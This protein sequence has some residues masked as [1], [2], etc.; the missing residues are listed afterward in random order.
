MSKK[1][2]EQ[3]EKTLVL[4]DLTH[5]YLDLYI[6]QA[7]FSLLDRIIDVKGQLER[8]FGS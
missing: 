5:N 6:P 2:L 4:L 3:H 8:R 7:K 1:V